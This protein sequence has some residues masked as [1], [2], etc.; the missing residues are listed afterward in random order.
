MVGSLVTQD[1]RRLDRGMI[2]RGLDVIGSVAVEDE[3]E[4]R[5]DRGLI[6]RGLEALGLE[7]S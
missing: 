1:D 6:L 7:S 5:L 3:D 2:L 4:A